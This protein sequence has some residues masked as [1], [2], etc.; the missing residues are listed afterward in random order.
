MAFPRAP[1]MLTQPHTPGPTPAVLP[2]GSGVRSRK[3]HF[4]QASQ[5]IRATFRCSD[6]PGQPWRVSGGGPTCREPGMRTGPSELK[7]L[8]GTPVARGMLVGQGPQLQSRRR[9]LQTSDR[10]PPGKCVPTAQ[11]RAQS[12]AQSAGAWHTRSTTGVDLWAWGGTLIQCTQPAN[13][14]GVA[15]TPG[16]GVSVWTRWEGTAGETGVLTGGF[17]FSRRDPTS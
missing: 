12:R 8:L 2:R 5:G 7:G 4:K 9:C 1:G 13:V 6:W 10:P 14:S 15:L 16:L 3:T 17:S 11:G